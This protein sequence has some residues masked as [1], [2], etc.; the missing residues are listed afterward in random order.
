MPPEWLLEAPPGCNQD[1]FDPKCF[2]CKGKMI[3]TEIP[4]KWMEQE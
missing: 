1:D 3:E 4:Q 2:V